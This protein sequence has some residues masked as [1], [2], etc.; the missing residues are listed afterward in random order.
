[1]TRWLV[2]TRPRPDA[3]LRL[4]C[5]P[6]AGGNAGAFDRWGEL[7]PDWVEVCAVQYPGRRERAQEPPM[8]R[9]SQLVTALESEVV[10]RMDRPYVVFGNSLGA[11]VAFEL[12]HR[13]RRRNGPSPVRLVVSC[14]PAPHLP[15]PLPD[16]PSLSDAEVMTE[17][18]RRGTMP[19]D[20]AEHPELRA[21]A[22]PA[23]R[24]DYELAATFR[25]RDRGPVAVPI[26]AIGGAEDHYVPPPALRAWAEVTTGQFTSVVLPGGHDLL[27]RPQDGLVRTVRDQL[28]A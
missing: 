6:F 21:L 10:S 2:T 3:T 19:A 27:T 1:M 26:H 12:V 14:S 4:L 28:P 18:V 20:L 7:M 22:V 11:K 17:L 25:Y 16:L 5:L 8:R 13:V 15:E 24:A 9:M 23:I